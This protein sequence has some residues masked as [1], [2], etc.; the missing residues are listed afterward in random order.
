MKG[1]HL[2]ALIADASPDLAQHWP[3]HIRVGNMAAVYSPTRM[4]PKM[5]RKAAAKAAYER[6][7]GLEALMPHGTVLP[8]LPRTRLRPSE[9]EP[10]LL[11]NGAEITK[12]S[13]RLRNRRQYQLQIRYDL[14]TAATWLGAD[15]GD[16]DERMRHRVTRHVD[17]VLASLPCET[18]ALP[19]APGMATNRALLIDAQSETA[20]DK[21]VEEIDRLWT[22]GLRIR[23]IGPS[24][25]V[26]FA[27]IGFTVIA[28]AEITAAFSRLALTEDA[29]SVTIA[30]ARKAC[31]KAKP[32][33][34]ADINE[35]AEL[36]QVAQAT[37]RQPF[38]KIFLWSEGRAATTAT[39]NRKVA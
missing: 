38:P 34:F 7:V 21:A 10:M 29:D 27:S 16:A 35:A 17:A 36:V 2:L 30:K 11:A 20:L 33:N 15:R 18:L 12:I 26:S 6:Q 1:T 9:F 37:K 19:I 28:R 39:E 14:E 32:E 3:D 24:P 25:A 23:L 31:L 8:A 5:G 22:D 13:N 4:L